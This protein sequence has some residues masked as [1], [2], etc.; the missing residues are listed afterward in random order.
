MVTNAT[1]PATQLAESNEP[2]TMEPK[3]KRGGR[4]K[5]QAV[6]KKPENAE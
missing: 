2:V 5:K 3:P 6:E 1:K 4:P